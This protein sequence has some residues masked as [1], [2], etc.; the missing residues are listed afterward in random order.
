MFKNSFFKKEF[1]DNLKNVLQ[2][3]KNELSVQITKYKIKNEILFKSFSFVNILMISPSLNI[4]KISDGSKGSE[5]KIK[6]HITDQLEIEHH[7]FSK[8]FSPIVWLEQ[9]VVSLNAMIQSRDVPSYQNFH[10][11]CN[12]RPNLSIFL[13]HVSILIRTTFLLVTNHYFQLMLMESI[14]R[15]H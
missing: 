2:N 11:T 1:S 13:V 15:R 6:S 10:S 7:Q 9:F 4:D 14:L 5:N 12:R 8:S 3:V